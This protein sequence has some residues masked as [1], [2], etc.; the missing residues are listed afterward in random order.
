L[1]CAP[2]AAHAFMSATAFASLGPLGGMLPP[3][4][5]RHEPLAAIFEPVP[6]MYPR[7]CS[8]EYALDA[9]LVCP[10][11]LSQFPSVPP[12]RYALKIV[13]HAGA[14]VPPLELPEPL[15]EPEPLDPLDEPLPPPELLEP[16]EPLDEL[17]DPPELP[18]LLV[19]PPLLLLPP[20][21]VLP[22]LLLLPLLLPLPPLLELV[23]PP[24]EPLEPL[25][26]LAPPSLP[27]P[28]LPVVG[29]VGRP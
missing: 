9:E 25:L 28:L 19:E 15:L 11:Q 20:L 5:E 7:P 23:L 18:E 24:L 22:P 26:L 8:H 12:A 29:A 6:E 14:A 2:A 4:Q 27:S 21:L 3:N 13:D 1:F 16:L 10:W 17:P